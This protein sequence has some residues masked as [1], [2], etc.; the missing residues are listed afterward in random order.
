MR[1]DGGFVG[2]ESVEAVEGTKVWSRGREAHGGM[3]AQ[4]AAPGTPLNP[5]DACA[6][7]NRGPHMLGFSSMAQMPSQIYPHEPPC[8]GTV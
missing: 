2:G 1:S 3:F 7:H 4:A 8:S 6:A 5:N